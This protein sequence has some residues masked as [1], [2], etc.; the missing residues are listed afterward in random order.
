MSPGCVIL[1]SNLLYGKGG[2]SRLEALNQVMEADEGATT[3]ARLSCFHIEFLLKSI[4]NHSEIDDQVNS[5]GK[6]W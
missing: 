4:Y 5:V 2:E 3:Y 1:K 6:V